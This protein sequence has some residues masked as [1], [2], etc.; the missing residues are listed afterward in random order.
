M[1]FFLGLLKQKSVIQLVGIAALC[2]L[3]WYAG[4]M[5]AFAGKVPLASEFNRLLTILGIVFGWAVYVLLSQAVAK[6]TDQRLI[7][8]LSAPQVDP[9]QAAIA[10]AQDA[11]V[12][13]V[14]HKFEEALLTLKEAR[15]K[16]RRGKHYLYELPWYI[17]IGAP[18]SGKTTALVNSGLRFPLSE[19]LGKG[20][21]RGVAG[22]R[23]CD[24]FFGEEAVFLD[25]AG[26]YTTQDSH[27]AVDA[28]AW[29]GFLDLIKKYRPRQPINGVLVTMSMSDLLQ[30]TE[31]ERSQ[32]A[33]EVRQ[34]IQE[35]YQVLRVR[36]P[37]YVL[38]TKCDLVAGF[39]DFFFD[40][41]QEERS[42]VWGETFPGGG[43]E[44]AEDLIARFGAGYDQLL[45][46]LNGRT[47][48]RLEEEKDIQRRG[49]ILDFPQQME[50]LKPAMMSFL[51]DTFAVSRFEAAALLRGVYFTS[52]T[53]EGTP[54][55]Q[56][57]GRLA[58]AYGFDRQ[59]Q[60]V[61]SGRGKTYFI[62]RLLKEVVIPEAELSGVDPGVERRRRWRQWAVCGC[63][64]L[65]AVGLC[66]VWSLSYARNHRAIERVQE[67]IQSYQTLSREA[68][69][70]EI[71]I[72]SLL[73]RLNLLQ[74]AH[75]VYEDSSWWMRF[76]LY[77]GEKLQSEI[78]RVYSHLL[79]NDLLPL[80]KTRL[81]QRLRE[82]LQA[83]K[84]ED[85]QILYELLKVY[86]MLGD[87]TRMDIKLAG[88]SVQKDWEQSFSRE[89]QIQSELKL[90][91]SRLLNEPVDAIELNKPLI[92]DVRKRLN[93]IPL[94]MQIYAHLKSEALPDHSH[95][96]L[97][98]EI[99]GRYGDQVF[100]TADGQ[101]LQ[102][103]VI[104]GL[105]THKGYTAFF[106]LQ[107]LGFVKK[108]LEQNWVSENPAADKAS[109]LNRL[110][111]DLQKLYFAEYERMW[112]SLL[113]NLRIRKA[114]GIHQSVQILD[115]L[116]APD[117]PIRPLLE[118]VNRNTVLTAEPTADLSGKSKEKGT[119]DE[120][121]PI[122]PRQTSQEDV[123]PE[124]LIEMERRFKDL[125]S[126]V[127]GSEKSPPPIERV[128]RSL[129]DLRDLM[130]QIGNA[131]KSEEQALKMARERMSGAGASDVIK[132]AQMEF[133]RLPEPLRGWFQQL[134]AFGWKLTLDSAKS[135]LQSIW[136]TEVLA[137]YQAGLDH[138]Y[139]LFKNSGHDTTMADFCRFFAPNGV[140]DQ[141]FKNHLK[142][143]VDTSRSPWRQ[144]SMDNQG[145]HL[146][147][148]MLKQFQ[149]AAKIRET[150]FSAGGSTPSI[151]F[152][153]KPLFLDENVEAF[154]L[155]LEGQPI[156][157][158]HGPTRSVKFKW[159]GP[160]TDLGVR[161][162]FQT[163]DG[164]E[165]NQAE[166]G[167]WAWFRIL[168]KATVER[169]NLLDRF[170]ATFQQAGFKARFELHASSVDNP[171][172]LTEL[173][174]FRCPGSF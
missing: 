6:R 72:R 38:F 141:F 14:R 165:I 148:E 150:F 121:L 127:A 91:T 153:L 124:P 128:L 67:L 173:Q 155:N 12:S 143:F 74:Q 142:P 41:G 95:D 108:A 88:I 140:L 94:A 160:Q 98:P 136:K 44:S 166:E 58:E 30:R 75:A 106:K 79:K 43:S 134:T 119:A 73:V 107:G 57:L 174:S 167:P 161:L 78:N 29:T 60:P 53:Q 97:L 24:W 110:Y 17:I 158:R 42:Q 170:V 65:L 144:L 54:I 137:A 120:K 126:L 146:S 61:F 157:Y 70:Q 13:D 47:F 10:Q 37:V 32:H 113:D 34:R 7:N 76:G 162:T 20:S 149:Y 90:H 118:T 115:L 102:A 71:G 163:L 112:R 171:F 49:L 55:D 111:D 87:P 100:T 96:F 168:D 11:E 156:Q 16:G 159:P 86:L 164:R 89:P 15:S 138:R 92:V 35:L 139:P 103:L 81:E 45:A 5:V 26:R 19:K 4:P 2:A 145:M 59:N 50:L 9:A 8:E 131:A 117:S 18:G 62:T 25:T 105:Y 3:I 123:A 33:H 22:T 40:L 114:Q 52:G 21:V 85:S 133:S 56:M 80:I 152:E 1:K 125:N 48:R 93:A 172:K 82:R 122:R 51:Y 116:T 36:F 109:D 151:E 101:A 64:V 63:L 99:L 104:P 46:R 69:G 84:T 135:E 27:Q 23:N 83:G 130:M 31:E 147:P 28:A 68:A 154:R 66:A 39:N 169:T 129:A 132:R 77:Q